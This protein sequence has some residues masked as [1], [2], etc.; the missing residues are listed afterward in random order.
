MKNQMITISEQELKN[1]GILDNDGDIATIELGQ[2]PGIMLL[3]RRDEVL[4][5][6]CNSYGF[7][8]EELSK[9]EFGI[10]EWIG[11]GSVTC[12][13]LGGGTLVGFGYN[14]IQMIVL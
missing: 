4:Q 9:Y 2:I 5:S 11:F 6:Y 8:I 12:F 7:T 3:L 14:E 1:A 13:E 10:D